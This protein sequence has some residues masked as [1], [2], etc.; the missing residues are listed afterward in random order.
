MKV[1]DLP[2]EMISISNIKGGFPKPIR[3]R[4]QL[5]DEPMQVIK[6][7]KIKVTN[8]IKTC[9]IVNQVYTCTSVINQTEKIYV[10]RFNTASCA[11]VLYKI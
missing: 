7:D 3:F 9:G 2:I 10:L 8:I 5:N 1:Y 6:I 11:W 4:M